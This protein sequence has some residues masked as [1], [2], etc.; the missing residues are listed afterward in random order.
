[1]APTQ[2]MATRLNL[3]QISAHSTPA[4][5]PRRVR[6]DCAGAGLTAVV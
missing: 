5:S 1:M 6:G 2:T 3:R 4:F